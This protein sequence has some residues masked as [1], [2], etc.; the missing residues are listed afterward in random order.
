MSPIRPIFQEGERL[1][2][3]RLNAAVEYLRSQLRRALLSPLS[4]GVAT[5]LELS[6]AAGASNVTVAPGVAIEGRGRLLVLSDAMTFDVA[7]VQTQITDLAVGDKFSICLMLDDSSA[8]FDPCAP[9]LPMEVVEKV[10]LGFRKIP[11]VAGVAFPPAS[12]LAFL[13]SL[14]PVLQGAWDEL[15]PA[16]RTSA[17]FCVRLGHA[18][19]DGTSIVSVSMSDRAGVVPRFGGIRNSFGDPTML[20]GRDASNKPHLGVAV[21]TTFGPDAPT[22]FQGT[23]GFYTSLNV[24]G[25]AA[26]QQP[27]TFNSTAG[28]PEAQAAVVASDVGEPPAGRVNQA[29][30]RVFE[31]A[32]GRPGAAAGVSGVLAVSMELDVDAAALQG[33]MPIP[34][35]GVPLALSTANPT[36]PTPKVA[37]FRPDIDYPH[38]IG[39]S[40]AASSTSSAGTTT[41]PVAMAGI[42]NAY[43]RTAVD[44]GAELTPDYLHIVGDHYPLKAATTGDLVVGRSALAALGSLVT[45]APVWVVQPYPKP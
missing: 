6:Q 45:P 43:I 3:R 2:A 7:D 33:F 20:L 12:L 14:A 15:D 9:H 11:V 39:L 36:L 24:Q 1:T 10:K 30:K 8:S 23:V 21:A 13:A 37:A 19:W 40:A 27:V 34:A 28:G 32:G 22:A 41:V 4:S 44:A 35:E 25:T 26:F 17:E 42:V 31:A 5:G 38:L 18:T 29:N 16:G